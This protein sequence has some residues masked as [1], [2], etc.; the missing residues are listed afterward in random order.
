MDLRTDW[1]K[2]LYK[3]K[4]TGKTIAYYFN[5]DGLTSLVPPPPLLLSDADDS[6]ESCVE[7]STN[8]Q[9]SSSKSHSNRTD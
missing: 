6:D 3:D 8:R 4:K 2:A 5:K 9:P 1:T 7:G